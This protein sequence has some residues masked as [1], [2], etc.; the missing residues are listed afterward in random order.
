MNG[1]VLAVNGSVRAVTSEMTIRASRI[2]VESSTSQGKAASFSSLARALEAN[3]SPSKAKAF[4][5][6]CLFARWRWSKSLASFEP[7]VRSSLISLLMSIQRLDQIPFN[8][9]AKRQRPC[10]VN[11]GEQHPRLGRC[12]RS[13]DVPLHTV[14][15]V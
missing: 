9:F 3:Q 13:W 6:A 5:Q 10:G 4:G 1:K 7:T 12:R 15:R 8:K 2:R 11:R 14:R